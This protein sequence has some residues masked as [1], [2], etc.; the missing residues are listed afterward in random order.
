MFQAFKSECL[1]DLSV[2][3]T[4]SMRSLIHSSVQISREYPLLFNAKNTNRPTD[5]AE[6]FSDSFSVL[7]FMRE[8][9][10]TRDGCA[11][12]RTPD[13]NSNPKTNKQKFKYIFQ[14]KKSLRF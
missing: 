11:I 13:P 14:K 2:Q 5:R 12:Q 7:P 9:A 3:F 8:I 10:L 1:V 6:C 4:L